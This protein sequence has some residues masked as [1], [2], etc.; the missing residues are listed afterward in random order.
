M[1][2]INK[3]IERL[4]WSKEPKGLYEPIAYVLAS[5]GK[6]LRPTLA[7]TAAEVVLN[8]GLISGTALDD[9]LPAALALEVFHNFTLLHDD[10]MDHSAV[11]RGKPTVHVQ[12][13]QN[14]AILSG[15]Q[16]LIE[17]YKLLERVPADKLPRTLRLF[18]EMATGVCE[19]QQLDVDFEHMSQVSID[20]YMTMIE[21]KTSV[22]IAYAM[23]I[24]GYIAGASE[25]QEKALYEYGLHI[26]LAF[27]IQDDILDVYGDPKTFGKAIGGDICCNKKT[28][29]LLTALERA[30]AES[31]AELLQWMMTTD[32]DAEKIKA[33]TEL[34]DRLG[35]REE[36]ESV[37]EE[38]T[39]LAL[40][41]LDRLPQ[42]TAT[43]RLRVLAERLVT[44]KR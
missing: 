11:R 17:A 20:D 4:D 10:V 40:A 31:K 24:G 41:A 13:N 15:D 2:D 35:V 8:G 7:L 27:Q 25:A 16:M 12:W 3:E 38:H 36:A 18:N 39:A 32:R 28:I 23:R 9:V 44:R 1:I 43:E 5:G 29:L 26:G 30:D 6:R 21:K 22:L 37:M 33:V 14:T 19:G 42:N 34:Y